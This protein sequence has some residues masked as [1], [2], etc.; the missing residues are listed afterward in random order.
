MARP[1]LAGKRSPAVVSHCIPVAPDVPSL[2]RLPW[3][4]T[5]LFEFRVTKGA[6][7]LVLMEPP[8]SILILPDELVA[9]IVLVAFEIVVSAR[10]GESD[11]GKKAAA[12]RAAAAAESIKRCLVN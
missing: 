10:A 3:F 11:A 5:K 1:V 7:A 12:D 2:I 4:R 6:A 8:V 9:R